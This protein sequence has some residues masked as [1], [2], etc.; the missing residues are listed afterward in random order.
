MLHVVAHA[1]PRQLLWRSHEEGLALWSRLLALLPAALC[2]MPDHVHLLTERYHPMDFARLMSGY[3]RWRHQHRGG[4]ARGGVWLPHPQPVRPAGRLH[5]QRTHRYI[6]LNPCRDGLAGDPLAWV[7]STHRDSVGLALPAVLRPVRHPER[8]HHHISADASVAAEGSALPLR[9]VDA[10]RPGWGSLVAAVSALTRT[11]VE[12]LAQP[13]IP[14]QL[15]VAAARELGG[16][17]AGQIAA[18]LGVSRWTLQREPGVQ[19]DA[20]ELVARI[21]DEARFP[22][23]GPQRLDRAPRWRRYMEAQPDRRRRKDWM[24]S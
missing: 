13:G 16:M 12:R 17:R 22:A 21:V 14:R 8:L 23:L 20:L 11:P 2:L 18:S 9:R 24:W 7:Y 19:R 6:A 4:E 5:L 15:L 10:G 1:R 3:A